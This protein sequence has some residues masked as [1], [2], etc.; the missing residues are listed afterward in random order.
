MIM[1][2]I[3]H[4]LSLFLFLARV[5]FLISIGVYGSCFSRFYIT[6]Y[7]SGALKSFYWEMLALWAQLIPYSF[8]GVA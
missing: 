6:L 4:P 3:H 7:S 8:T 2:I 5:S 1:C